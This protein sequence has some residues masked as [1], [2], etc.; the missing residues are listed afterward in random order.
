M[1]LQSTKQDSDIDMVTRL[2]EVFASA[3]PAAT[4]GSCGLD[5]RMTWPEFEHQLGSPQMETYFKSLDLDT[6]EA[7]GLFSLLDIEETGAVDAEDFIMGC[8][9]L[10][11]PAR[12]IDLATLMAETRRLGRLL[13]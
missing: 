12:A 11:G 7:K 9:R 8:L 5:A 10:R 4:T 1:G 13:R 2:R 6:S 3:R